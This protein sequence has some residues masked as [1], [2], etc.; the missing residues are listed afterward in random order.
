MMMLIQRMRKKLVEYEVPRENYSHKV[1]GCLEFEICPHLSSL[2]LI[3]V[4]C[5]YFPPIFHMGKENS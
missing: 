5:C 3:Y 2:A 4:L 1:F